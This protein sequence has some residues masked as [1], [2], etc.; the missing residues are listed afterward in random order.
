[1]YEIKLELTKIKKKI[2]YDVYLQPGV[3]QRAG[4]NTN[5]S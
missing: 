2:R 4:I 1:M 3:F 5:V